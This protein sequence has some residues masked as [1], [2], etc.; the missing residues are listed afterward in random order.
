MP[1]P[2][3]AKRA[4]DS[5]TQG[6]KPTR[7]T[8]SPPAI[9]RPA[10]IPLKPRS[11]VIKFVD[12]NLE[13]LAESQEKTKKQ[14]DAHPNHFINAQIHGKTL[15]VIFKENKHGDEEA[16]INEAAFSAIASL[17]IKPGLT[18]DQHLVEQYPG[19]MLG[20]QLSSA[21]IAG[22]ASV[23]YSK[24]LAPFKENDSL[25]KITFEYGCIKT[26][27]LPTNVEQR[28]KEKGFVFLTDV[29]HGFFT[30]LLKQHRNP[31]S[32]IK[33]DME[34]IGNVLMVA[35]ELEEDD[36]HKGNI[37]C[38]AREVNGE[39]I[40]TFFK[41]DHD[42]MFIDKIMSYKDARFANLLYGGDAFL[43]TPEDLLNFPDIKSGNHYW[44]TK[45]PFFVKKEKAYIDADERAAFASLKDDPEFQRAKWKYCLKFLLLPES[46]VRES[47][48]RILSEANANDAD[49]IAEIEHAIFSKVSELRTAAFSLKE[50]RDYLKSPEG[51][52]DITALHAEFNQYAGNMNFS[53]ALHTKTCEVLDLHS[54]IKND[55]TP[56]H[57]AL[58]ADDYRFEETMPYYQQYANKKNE[59]GETPLDVI[60]E[61]AHRKN[62]AYTWSIINHL[63]KFG[64]KLNQA[65][66]PRNA[67]EEETK[68]Q[69]GLTS[70]QQFEY[71]L[72]QIRNNPKRS[73]KRKKKLALKLISD[74]RKTLGEHNLKIILEKTK[75][76]DPNYRFLMRL[77]TKGWLRRKRKGLYGKTSTFV[78][79]ARLVE[80]EQ[81]EKIEPSTPAMLARQSHL[82]AHST[83][84]HRA[85]A[86]PPPQD[87]PNIR[88]VYGNY[89]RRSY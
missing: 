67:K 10:A 9:A 73:L 43:I 8:Y 65:I 30:E 33:I 62:N 46:L 89:F 84:R 27:K 6:I 40:V 12:L 36:L 25:R 75:T 47:L 71:A 74:N 29:A 11:Q 22:V 51:D 81:S 16:S 68:Y 82:L 85:T 7:P 39:T 57:I 18:P 4:K 56:L 60:A 23:N 20:G 70:L 50:F 66:F 41:I 34:S 48:T 86:T 54:Q 26:E 19:K 55:D 44:P 80:A 78:K 2:N 42:L 35:H 58:R 13:E 24:T 5:A 17:M 83:F 31:R 1:N 59:E 15:P 14:K 3:A 72:T 37:G 69:K 53:K 87:G 38:Y 79:L 21:K 32:K 45:N 88:T 64:A 28:N 76:L 77:R 61:V 63:K 52:A 49:K